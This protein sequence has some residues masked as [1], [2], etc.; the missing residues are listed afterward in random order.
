[1]VGVGLD[2]RNDTTP[3]PTERGRYFTELVTSD[4]VRWLRSVIAKQA[5]PAAGKGR[6]GAAQ[7]ST[8]AYL[9]HESNHAPLQVPA[10]YIDGGCADGI[11]ASQP[12]RRIVCGMMRAVDSSLKNVTDA[13]KELGVWDS[14]SKHAPL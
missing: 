4:A 9:A 13:Y 3:V 7:K 10:Y 14:T 11:P 8:F 1:M 2:L 5:G 12:E 6:E